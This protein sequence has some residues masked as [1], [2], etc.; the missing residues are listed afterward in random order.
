MIREEI[1]PTI[2][3]QQRWRWASRSTRF[4]DLLL[5]LVSRDI[6]ARY[7]RSW[8]GPA[9]AVLQPLILMVL[10]TL[11]RSFVEIPSDGVPAVIFSY[12]ALVPWTFL[13]NAVTLCGP[14]IITNAAILKKVALP[15]EIFPLAAVVTALFDFA[16]ASIILVG[17]ILW[18]RIPAT[19]SWLWTPLLVLI[20]AAM[21]LAVGMIVA[22]LGSYKRDF[23]FATPFLMQFWLYAT[24][25][26][27]P[28][29]SVPQDKRALYMLNPMVG[30]VEGF[31]NILIHGTPPPMD[32][33]AVSAV[34]ALGLL[35]VAWLI[36]RPLSQYFADAI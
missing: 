25:V 24:P 32:A 4:A 11:L 15:R 35:L 34:V 36:F 31:R 2:A 16:I 17:M 10:F 21:A 13:T 26:I 22:A 28:L 8:L 19:W 27:Y 30:V 14:S 12:S 1:T 5:A 20:T 33:L 7:R 9:W 18:Y 23:V 3:T 29:S 6:R